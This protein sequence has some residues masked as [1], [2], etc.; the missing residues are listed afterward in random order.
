M[1]EKDNNS[2]VRKLVRDRDRVAVIVWVSE[3][4]VV[5]AIKRHCLAE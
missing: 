3:E 1:V 4:D 5:L 2:L